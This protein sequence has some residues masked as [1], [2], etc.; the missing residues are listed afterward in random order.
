[1]PTRLTV[2]D[3]IHATPGSAGL[4]LSSTLDKNIGDE[5]VRIPTGVHGPPPGMVGLILGRS[6]QTLRGLMVIP[7]VVDSD[8]TG[9]IEV[10]VYAFP[11]CRFVIQKGERI[12]QMI[13]M[14]YKK[15]GNMTKK[16]VQ[17]DQYGSL[18]VTSE[19]VSEMTWRFQRLQIPKRKKD[20]RKQKQ[21]RRR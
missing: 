4:D 7:G 16:M 19:S 18:N 2:L 9:E 12:A 3:L 13:V 6:S 20:I 8:Y 1:M 15:L 11:R 10:M 21:R 17:K 5:V 14:D